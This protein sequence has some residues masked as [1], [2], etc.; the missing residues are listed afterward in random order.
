M[1]ET[2]SGKIVA[3]EH[4]ASRL[5]RFVA[6]QDYLGQILLPFRFPGREKCEW[7]HKL[8]SYSQNEKTA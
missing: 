7:N 4:Y 8:L 1:Q 5:P 3:Q 2:S 6:E